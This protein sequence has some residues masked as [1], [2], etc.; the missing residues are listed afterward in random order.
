[1]CCWQK[2]KPTLLLNV[3]AHVD[4][5]TVIPN[6]AVAFQDDSVVLVADARRIRLNM[7]YYQVIRLAGQH[8]Y[9]AVVAPSDSDSRYHILLDSATMLVPGGESDR[10]LE[11]GSSATLVVT[12]AELAPGTKVLHIFVEGKSMAVTDSSLTVAPPQHR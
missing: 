2:E 5:H 6:A 11:N 7:P 3:V 10:P 12:D 1:M 9:P 8:V 4:Q